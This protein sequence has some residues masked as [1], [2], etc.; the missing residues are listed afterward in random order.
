MPDDLEVGLEREQRPHAL[1]HDHVV[2]GEEH[3]DA[4]VPH[5]PPFKRVDALETRWLATRAPGVLAPSPRTAC[6]LVLQAVVGVLSARDDIE[7]VD[8]RIESSVTSVSWIPSEAVT[9]PS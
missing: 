6:P 4:A 8:M 7:E 3:R 9:G 1:A 2:V 5:G